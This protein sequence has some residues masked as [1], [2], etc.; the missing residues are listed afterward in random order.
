M[1]T[2]NTVTRIE[3]YWDAQVP[4]DE[5]WAYRVY[6]GEHEESGALED[7]SGGLDLPADASRSDLQQAVQSIAFV[8]GVEIDADD[9]AYE[10]L[11]GGYAF[12]IAS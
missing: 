9:V 4:D 7:H 1:T 12:W 6:R 5:G 8:E 3:I 11:L 2:E 10:P